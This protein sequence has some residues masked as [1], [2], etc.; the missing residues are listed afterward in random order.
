M[1]TLGYKAAWRSASCLSLASLAI[2]APTAFAQDV[3]GDAA[4]RTAAAQAPAV[5]GDAARTAS[6]QAPGKA[7]PPPGKDG[8][9]ILVTGSR[10]RRADNYTSPEPMLVLTQDSIHEQG[11]ASI[12]DALQSLAVTG[13]GSQYNGYY[14]ASGVQ[15]GGNGSSTIGLRGLGADRTLVLLNGR[16]LSPA[17]THGSV[18]DVDL[19]TLPSILVKRIE[20]LKAGASSIYGS[21]AIAGVVN[22]VTDDDLVG[23]K[24]D[25]GISV[26]EMGAGVDRH[27]SAAY[28][29]HGDDWKFVAAVDWRKRSAVTYGDS[30]F[31]N[32]PRTLLRGDYGL[33]STDLANAN[34]CWTV[35]NGGTT[36][37]SIGIDGSGT[38]Y[39]PTAGSAGTSLANYSAVSLY[40]R[41]SYDPAMSQQDI[42]TPV[43]TLNVFAKGSY[44]L[45]ALGEAELYSEFLFSHRKSSNN[46]YTQLT[47]DYP[48]GSPLLG[49]DFQGDAFSGPTNLSN[50]QNVAVRA[51]IGFGLADA[52]QTVNFYRAN[53]GLR[54]DLGIGDWRYDVYGSYSWTRAR[55]TQD[56]LITSHIAQSLNVVANGDGS[57]SCADP[58]GG[59]VA[60]PSL[61]TAT[62]GGNLSQAYRN[63]VM[64][65]TVG[66]TR[67]DEFVG[68]ANFDGSLFRLPGGMA[69]AA[70]GAEFRHSHLNDQPSAQSQDNDF[71]LS[72]TAAPT[73]GSDDVWEL[74]GELNLPV[75]ANLPG[76]Y[77]LN[78]DGS[79]RY[80]HYRSYGGE[81]TY[82][83]QAEYSPV[84]GATFRASYGTSYRAPSLAQ[85]YLGKTSSFLSASNDPCANPETTTELTNCEKVGL[86]ATTPSGVP[87]GTNV[88]STSIT[89]DAA[90]GRS[91][92]LK[93][94]TSNNL[95]AG[96]VLEPVMPAW[97]GH[98]SFSA[99]YF[100][101]TVDNSITKFGAA[102]I[103]ASCYNAVAFNANEGYCA[104]ITRDA[105]GAATVVDN[106][107]NIAK[108]RTRGI[109]FDLAYA[110]DIGP[111][112]FNLSGILTKYF[113]QA[114]RNFADGALI[115][116][117][118]TVDEP[119]W[120]AS[121]NASYTVQRVT[122]HY[123]VDWIGGTSQKATAKYE[124]T[125]SSGTF[126]ASSYT[127]LMT[128]FKLSTPDYFLH[129][130]S[131]SFN[132]NDDF[133]LTM[134]VRNLF[135][136]QPP[137]ITNYSGI[138][139]AT[140]GN[141]PVYSGYDFYGRTFFANVTTDF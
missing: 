120:T 15:P 110:H 42:V 113:E 126:S 49:A 47:L 103:L 33:T 127:E 132:V 106:Y 43:E 55:Y 104:L 107:R 71:Y 133:R 111:G 61:S 92:G 24:M 30:K 94:E 21:D 44:Q 54:G 31:A 58:T 89:V 20:V 65:N 140:T 97:A 14:G 122:F 5:P 19:N 96:L 90:G 64:E 72:S 38:R 34:K 6:V 17:G 1:N 79:G 57:F 22:I 98:L 7:S 27:L 85:Q 137:S 119:A 115:D 2:A 10:I 70:I 125:D 75:L 124:A 131:V 112:Q 11:F 53:T 45:H 56:A 91:V 123:G 130:V 40:T 4:A 128:D 59:C 81:W 9:T 139:Y 13:G 93:A 60:A 109:E 86:I 134:G 82:K 28:G 36:I 32:C 35:Y 95:S 100:A 121:L 16:R 101:I 136:R 116:A 26:P 73:V 68:S 117:N 67:T 39:R 76:V 78:L 52:T 25:A 66:H 141:A 135:D 46:A 99:D 118:G 18:S 77:A 12:V 8:D 41:D 69:K 74:F 37:N 88:P 63:W 102:N 50:G 29:A 83:G 84:R 87:T 114:T 48:Q 108:Q 129:N 51:L 138:P 62:V 3:A 105:T 23:P 80:T